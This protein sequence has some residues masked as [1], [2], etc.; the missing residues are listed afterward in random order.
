MQSSRAGVHVVGLG[1]D[2]VELPGNVTRHAPT[3]YAGF[4]AMAG[5]ARLCLDVSTYPGGANDR[6]FSYSLNRAVCLTNAAGYLR[7]AYAGTDAMQ[8]YS[9]AQPAALAAGISALLSDTHRLRD[10]GEAG[11]RVT[12]DRQNWRVRLQAMLDCL[13]ANP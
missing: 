8:F 2:R 5:R 6:V 13:A 4:F 12:L 10:M 1:W 9:P 11:R 7:E 3:D